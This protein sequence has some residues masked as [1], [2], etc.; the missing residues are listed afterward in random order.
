MRI[1][2]ISILIFFSAF[3]FSYAG[4]G[5]I[6]LSFSNIA[7][8]TDWQGSEEDSYNF[9]I[10]GKWTDEWLYRA[11]ELQYGASFCYGKNSAG[12][13]VVTNDDIAIYCRGMKEWKEKW[14]ID[15]Y[16]RLKGKYQIEKEEYQSYF[17]L[18]LMKEE[19]YIFQLK[20][21][22]L[23]DFGVRYCTGISLSQ[24]WSNEDD[25]LGILGECTLKLEYRNFIFE[26]DD[27]DIFWNDEM[28]YI[29]FPISLRFEKDFWKVEKKWLV[30]G[31]E[32]QIGS[33][34]TF[35]IGVKYAF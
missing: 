2:T 12:K 3:Q 28:T 17:Q 7:V 25:S 34:S 24:R 6:S 19:D 15:Y 20:S 26:I 32:D 35:T 13:K 4:V 27:G 30:R 29:D 22:P 5:E 21:N 1:I 33:K 10:S 14:G 16:I 18:G 8:T 23:Y 11:W 9:L 31:N